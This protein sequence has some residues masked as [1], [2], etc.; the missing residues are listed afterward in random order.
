[1]GAQYFDEVI[2]FAEER[3]DLSTFPKGEITFGLIELFSDAAHRATNVPIMIARGNEEGPI[4][5][6]LG[7]V[8]GNE[9][10]GI[11]TIHSLFSELDP[12]T[13][14]GTV[15]AIPV[16]NMHGYLTK[17]RYFLDSKDLNRV[18]P[19]KEKG[20]PSEIFAYRLYN[21]V[22]SLFDYMID[23]HTASFGRE[24]SHYVRADLSNPTIQK[25]A[26][27]Q[28]AEIIINTKTPAG[29]FRT[30]ATQ[31]GIPAITIELGNPQSYQKS[32]VK[33]G[34]VGITN[35]MKWKKMIPGEISLSVDTVTCSHSYWVRVDQGGVLEVIPNLCDT[36]AKDEKIGVLNDIFGQHIK[37]YHSPDSGI[38]V[39]KSTNPAVST[40]GRVI[41]LG[42]IGTIDKKHYPEDDVEDFDDDY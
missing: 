14:K 17:Q 24:N 11:M 30:F 28:D 25:M 29:S 3:I 16:V 9:L 41:H 6:V 18:L 20:S 1:M 39:G 31:E 37:D 40:G 8:H 34:F 35:F 42:I 2:S 38:V 4:L 32:M 10:N 23:I 36:V 27:L 5:G 26:E 7:V 12:K 22:I 15:I 13:M 33:S 21:R 19:G